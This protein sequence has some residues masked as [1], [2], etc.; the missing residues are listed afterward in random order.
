[1]CVSVKNGSAVFVRLNP[2]LFPSGKDL[3]QILCKSKIVTF[4]F[5][6][7]IPATYSEHCNRLLGE[8]VESPSLEISKS[9]L[10]NV[11]CSLL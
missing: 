6:F 10:D 2:I 1:V 4:F 5:L 7:F 8:A 3:L 9:R 11:L